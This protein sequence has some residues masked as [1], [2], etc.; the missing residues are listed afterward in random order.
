M[1]W[2]AVQQRPV[3][4]KHDSRDHYCMSLERDLERVRAEFLYNEEEDQQH[5]DDVRPQHPRCT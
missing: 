4:I 2:K 5:S 1:G 3:G